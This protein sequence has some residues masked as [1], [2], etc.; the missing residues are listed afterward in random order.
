MYATQPSRPTPRPTQ[1]SSSSYRVAPTPSAPPAQRSPRIQPRRRSRRFYHLTLASE[2]SL[3]L[4]INGLLLA[5]FSV[6]LVRLLPQMW[7]HQAELAAIETELTLTEKRVHTL[8]NT[9]Q[10]TFDPTQAPT[11]IEQESY[12][13]DK[14]KRRVV[15]KA[16]L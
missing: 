11:L 12:R 1:R 8:E 3:K 16:P 2:A 7:Q 5:G 9:F 6:A 13:V 14:N 15:W 4:F 10:A